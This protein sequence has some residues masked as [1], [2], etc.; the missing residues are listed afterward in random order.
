[1]PGI[2]TGM[3]WFETQ[4]QLGVVRVC[5]T[6]DVKYVSKHKRT[7]HC[8]SIGCLNR[9]EQRV[10]ERGRFLSLEWILVCF[11]FIRTREGRGT[12]V[13]G[14]PHYGCWGDAT[15]PRRNVPPHVCR[16]TCRPISTDSPPPVYTNTHRF[17]S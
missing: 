4:A 16:L 3:K 9:N 15:C 11:R 8:P 13:T 17:V 5:T 6:G 1:M 14:A 12:P 10:P 2:V 7:C